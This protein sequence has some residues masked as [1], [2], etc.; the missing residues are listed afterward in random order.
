GRGVARVLVVRRAA[1]RLAPRCG[2][3]GRAGARRLARDLVRIGRGEPGVACRCR[4][5]LVDC[6]VVAS[7]PM[8]T[9]AV[10]ASG[11]GTDFEAP[12]LAAHQGELGGRIVA[13]LTD[14]ADAPALEPAPRIRIEPLLLP[15]GPFQT[16]I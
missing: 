13:L 11:Q 15:L 2:V 7:T 8:R 5:S 1:H 6:G 12:A 14:R 4:A 9:L 16:P 10:L 3:G